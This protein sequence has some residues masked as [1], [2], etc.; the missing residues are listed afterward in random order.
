MRD[1]HVR[2]EDSVTV[3]GRTIAAGVTLDSLT[4]QVGFVTIF[5]QVKKFL[6]S[7]VALY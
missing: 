5:K 3:P 7:C 1:I 6:S 4:V 2:F